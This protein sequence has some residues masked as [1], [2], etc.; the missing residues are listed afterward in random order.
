MQWKQLEVHWPYFKSTVGGKWRA[1]TAADLDR[2]DGHREQ[3]L[4]ILQHRYGRTHAEAEREV[5]E[6]ERDVRDSRMR[7]PVGVLSAEGA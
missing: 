1:L 7:A 2:I 6:F 5:S 3:L 4:G